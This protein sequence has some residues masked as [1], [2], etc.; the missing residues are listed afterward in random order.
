MVTFFR[1]NMLLQLPGIFPAIRSPELSVH[2]GRQPLRGQH[3][4]QVREIFIMQPLNFI[5]SPITWEG[6][7]G[8]K[9]L[10][11]FYLYSS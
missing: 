11:V 10:T 8:G 1:C 5:H 6:G 9:L 2:P 4:V 3:K 7:G